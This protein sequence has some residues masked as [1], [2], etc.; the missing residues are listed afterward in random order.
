MVMKL[1]ELRKLPKSKLWELYDQKAGNVVSSLN[2]YRDE[3]M[4]REQRKQTNIL[5]GLTILMFIAAIIQVIVLFIMT[6][7]N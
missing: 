6:M 4:R 7:L 3:I 2:H 1:G 5:I